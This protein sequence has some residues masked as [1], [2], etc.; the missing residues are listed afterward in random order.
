MSLLPCPRTQ[1]THPSRCIVASLALLLCTVS[2][3]PCGVFITYGGPAGGHSAPT[4]QC[5]QPRGNGP[6]RLPTSPTICSWW[7]TSTRCTGGRRTGA[8][9]RRGCRSR[10]TN[11]LTEAL[12]APFKAIHAYRT[13]AATAHHDVP[14]PCAGNL[15][16]CGCF[17]D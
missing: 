9:G 5:V 11:S 8:Q 3:W 17:F 12:R 16:G 6:L 15:I 10:R 7:I 13:P 2:A 4:G 14:A 1:N